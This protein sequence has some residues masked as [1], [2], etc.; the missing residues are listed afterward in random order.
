MGWLSGLRLCGLHNLLICTFLLHFFN[1]SGEIV[2]SPVITSKCGNDGGR[3]TTYLGGFLMENRCPFSSEPCVP[4]CPL[5]RASL[6]PQYPFGQCAIAKISA[7][8]DELPRQI[9]ALKP[10]IDQLIDKK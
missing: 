9:A 1:Q 7:S 6:N 8:L 5:Y 10:L 2:I 3:C 4:A